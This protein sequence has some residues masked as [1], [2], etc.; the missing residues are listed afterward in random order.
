[1]NLSTL[2]D[3]IISRQHMK[4]ISDQAQ[5]AYSK[6]NKNSFLDTDDIISLGMEVYFRVKDKWN[7]E[8]SAFDTFLINC[9]KNDFYKVVRDSYA[10][11]RGGL[12]FTYV[13]GKDTGHSVINNVSIDSNKYD[14]EDGRIALTAKED[15][16]VEYNLLCNQ[17]AKNIPEHLKTQYKQMTD[18]DEELLIRAN[19]ACKGKNRCN[20]DDKMMAEYL[21]FSMKQFKSNKENI[22]KI[23]SDLMGRV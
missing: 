19:D 20:V 18:P 14:D 1:M 22:R 11:C 15:S 9:L 23:I 10:K 6:I 5:V 13:S 2:P 7:P 12:G 16:E 8:K 3:Q 21:G 17:I 4:Y